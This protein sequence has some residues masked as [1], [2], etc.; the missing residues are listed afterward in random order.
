MSKRLTSLRRISAVQDIIQRRAEAA[1]AAAERDRAALET[2][3]G[4]LD[5][6]A[7]SEGLRGDLAR[8]VD[9]QGRRLAQRE[10]A[11]TAEIARRA[12]HNQS[13]RLRQKLFDEARIRMER[14]EAAWAERRDLDRLIEDLAARADPLG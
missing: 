4:V 14:D 6:L 5:E 10:S 9:A 2:Q 7:Q 12:A 3:R 1:L 13:A 8:L 11:A